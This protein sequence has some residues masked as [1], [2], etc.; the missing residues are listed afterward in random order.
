MHVRMGLRGWSRRK[1]DAQAVSY[2]LIE[3]T[4]PLEVVGES[5]YQDALWRMVGG[6]RN[7]RVRQ[8]VIAVLLPD[9]K[10]QYDPHAVAVHVDQSLVGH[11]PRATA[12][13]VFVPL[14]GMYQ[15]ILPGEFIAVRGEL[16]GGSNGTDV[17]LGNLGVFLQWDPEAFGITDVPHGTNPSAGSWA[18]SRA[19]NRERPTD[20]TLAKTAER[21]AP[22]IAET[23]TKAQAEALG[24]SL[25]AME[26]DLS[27]LVDDLATI[28]VDACGKLLAQRLARF[29][30]TT[31]A[32]SASKQ[33]LQDLH[34]E[35]D[36]LSGSLEALVDE[37][38]D[39]DREDREALRWEASGAAADLLDRINAP[40]R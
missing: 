25:L 19:S 28:G 16:V 3:G 12:A 36:Q 6:K 20:V 40:V 33:Y 17:R 2:R 27:A 23:V 30:F 7:E 14:T 8:P 18:G 39:A 37:W 35:L 10:N 4:K 31:H 29:G 9:P 32:G 34:D 11:L 22:V 21:L 15:Q 26:S 13:L 1:P 38:A 24:R 5:H